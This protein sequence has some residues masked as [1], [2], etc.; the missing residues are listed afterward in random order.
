[1]SKRI[2]KTIG[3]LQKT[4]VITLTIDEIILKNKFRF[5]ELKLTLNNRNSVPKNKKS[6]I[7]E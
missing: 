4:M 3:F 7:Y 2:L 6:Q 5:D 1:M